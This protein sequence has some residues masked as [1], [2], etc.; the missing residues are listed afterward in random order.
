MS[1][2]LHDINELEAQVS[3][4]KTALHLE[5]KMHAQCRDELAAAH[6]KLQLAHKEKLDGD[7]ALTAAQVRTTALWRQKAFFF[8]FFF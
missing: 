6:A 7:M 3:A 1:V 5:Q 8:F 2:F 4:V